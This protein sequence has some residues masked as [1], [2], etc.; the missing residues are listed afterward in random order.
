MRHIVRPARAALLVALVTL[1]APV[2]AQKQS[3][4]AAGT[5]KDLRLPAKRSFTLPNG[6]QVD[7]VPFGQIPKTTLRLVVRSGNVNEAAD[8][9]WLADVTAD[10]MREG[11][12]RR[13]GAEV[14]TMFASMGGTLGISVGPDQTNVGADVLA[15][16]A[17]TAIALL[18]EVVRDAA[19]PE[20]EL[21]RV[22]AN[23]LRQLSI[24]RS[25]PQGLASEKFASLLFG[26]HPYGR[27]FPTEAMLNGYT[28]EQVRGFWREHYGAGRAKLY[29]AGVFDDAA[30]EAAVREAFGTW[31]RGTPAE[32]VAPPRMAAHRQSALIDRPDAPQSTIFVGLPVPD[33]SQR[34]WIPLQVTDALLGGAFGSRITRNIREEKGYTYSPYS[35]VS[36]HPGAAYW[37]EVADVTTNVTGASLKEIFGEIE[38]LQG[39]APPADELRGI[40]NNLAGIF[41]L[42]NA[43]RGGLIGRLAF[44]DLYGLGDA[45][46]TNYVRNLL[47]VTPADVQRITQTYLRPER[48]TL[49]VVGDRKTVE[50]Q[51]APYA[52]PV[53]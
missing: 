6:L 23:R 29:V 8:E 4:P 49:V 35:T 12:A 14:A 15:E 25:T 45:Y 21:P 10:L 40:Q 3:P 31:E 13:S 53:P 42:Q 19:L 26:D 11:T 46:L 18:A 48:M 17:P 43:S 16:H 34:D 50:A 39:E 9:V 27:T 32:R 41:T 5:P 44:V 22:K 37:A 30:I 20:S 1:A 36:A 7:L 28:I 51:V 33:P 2:G 38:R 24:S 47:A 52:A